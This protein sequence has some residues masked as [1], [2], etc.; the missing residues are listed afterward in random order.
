MDQLTSLTAEYSIVEKT[1]AKPDIRESNSAL[2]DSYFLL[3]GEE[4]KK[5]EPLGI[6]LPEKRHDIFRHIFQVALI[7][8]LIVKHS[9]VSNKNVLMDQAERYGLTHDRGRLDDLFALEDDAKYKR[10]EDKKY[11]GNNH[12]I[13]GMLRLEAEGFTPLYQEMALDHHLMGMGHSLTHRPAL[14]IEIKKKLAMPGADK[15]QI[16][17]DGVATLDTRYGIAGLALILAD[18]SKDYPYFDQQGNVKPED[19]YRKHTSSIE[20]F[21]ST[22]G[23]K[24]VNR[25]LHENHF[26]PN[27]ERHQSEILGK[28]FVLT[29][30]DFVKE[31]YGVDYEAAIVDAKGQWGN[32]DENIPGKWQEIQPKWDELVLGKQAERIIPLAPPPF[33][34]FPQLENRDIAADDK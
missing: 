32:E 11:N 1:E 20:A 26:P 23:D 15:A 4:Y 18:L 3:A 7:A 24:L 16:L 30:I 34:H 21:S 29:M 22:L 8:R 17:R 31:K 13:A 33:L 12:P 5:M 9:D 2:G 14:G 6:P 19:E 28:D 27:K 10:K 25:Q